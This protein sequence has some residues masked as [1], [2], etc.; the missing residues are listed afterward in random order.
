MVDN[1]SSSEGDIITHVFDDRE[2]VDAEVYCHILEAEII[3]WVKAKAAG[4]EYVRFQ[5]DGT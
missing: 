2:T 1:R 5:Q 4:K 3:S